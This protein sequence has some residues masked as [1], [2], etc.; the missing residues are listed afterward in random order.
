MSITIRHDLHVLSVFSSTP[1]SST[2]RGITRL[3]MWRSPSN[4]EAIRIHVANDEK[5]IYFAAAAAK[6]PNLCDLGRLM[7]NQVRVSKKF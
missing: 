5:R 2:G 3:R 1:L 6:N 7:I 4:A